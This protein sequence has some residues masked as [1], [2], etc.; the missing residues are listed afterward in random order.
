MIHRTR[1]SPLLPASGSSGVVV[2]RGR[3]LATWGDHL[4]PEMTFSVSKTFLSIVAGVGFDIGLLPGPEAPVVATVELPVPVSRTMRTITWRHLLQ[5]TSEW[6]GVLWGKPTWADAN[7]A[8]V[9]AVPGTGEPG[10]GWAYNDVR[11]NLLSLALTALFGRSLPDVLDE[12]VLTPI[13]VSRTWSWH[14][15][16]NS[17]INIGDTPTPVVSGGAHWGGGLW[18]S[19][20]DLALVG[21]LLARG[22][23]WNDRQVLSADWIE[24]SWR[25]CDLHPDY[26]YLWWLNDRG[27][28]YPGAPTTGRC[29]QGNGGR[30]LLWVD[31][32]RDLVI[33]SHW[34]DD[35]G[36]LVNAVSAAIPP[37]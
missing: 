21:M 30:H 25:S 14:G 28:V 13:G 34:G 4:V 5:Q 29:A 7:S 24:H 6:N 23:R 10:S 27:R 9:G 16:S 17:T 35:V 37:A 20:G 31:P 22:G 8:R 3:T 33:A 26:G 19:A 11:V 12:H 1:S 18:M 36:E 2:H 32:A 15:Y